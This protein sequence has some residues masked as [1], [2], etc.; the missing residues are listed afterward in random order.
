VKGQR[1][2]QEMRKSVD[3]DLKNLLAET[4]RIASLPDVVLARV[5]GLKP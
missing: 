1:T 3:A 4:R 2:V 5:V